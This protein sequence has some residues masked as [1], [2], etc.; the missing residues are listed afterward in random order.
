MLFHYKP[1]DGAT[2][3]GGFSKQALQNALEEIESGA[4]MRKTVI[5]YGIDRTILRRYKNKTPK[6]NKIEDKG[7]QYKGS[8]IFTLQDE[9]LVINYLLTWSKIIC[10]LTRM[11]AMKFASEYAQYLKKYH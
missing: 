3:R 10:G 7:S 9:K 8:Q 2:R 1:K 5:K 4:S 11:D 6:L